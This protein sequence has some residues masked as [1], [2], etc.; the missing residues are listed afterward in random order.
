[1][2]T[3]KT[4]NPHFDHRIKSQLLV[5]QNLNPEEKE[6]L[7]AD[8]YKLCQQ[9]F[10]NITYE[11]FCHLIPQSGAYKTYVMVYRNHNKEVVG[12]FALHLFYVEVAGKRTLVFRGQIGLLQEYRR[13]KANMYF[14][15]F[16]ILL[17][18]LRHPLS[19]VYCFLSIINPSMYA[20]LVKCLVLATPRYD[21]KNLS[22][23]M[24]IDR[25]REIFEFDKVE[26]SNSWTTNVRWTSMPSEGEINYWNNSS[27]PHIK[28]FLELNPDFKNGVGLITL[29]PF[30]WKNISLSSLNI[31]SY[32]LKKVSKQTA[33]T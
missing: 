10:G 2:K 32:I 18:R 13:S 28:Y 15:L 4:H 11:E 31:L 20:V 27:N 26:E 17:Y 24:L 23:A 6:K 29:M 25:L 8:L 22:N 33:H 5:L 3:E 1:M 14:V 12:F 30:S 9:V 21:R 19:P 16:I 7:S